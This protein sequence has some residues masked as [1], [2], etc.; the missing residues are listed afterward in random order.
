[1]TLTPTPCRPPD[2]LYAL[3]SN[4]P[5]AWSIV[6]A[7]STPGRRSV[8]CRSTGMPR[9]LS[10]TVMELSAW[11]TTS[12]RVQ[13]PASASSTALSTTSYT[14]WCRPRAPVEPMYMPGRR[15]TA[16]RPLRTW[17]WPALYSF[18][19]GFC[20]A[21]SPSLESGGKAT[22]FIT[23]ETA[24]GCPPDRVPTRSREPT[25][26]ASAVSHHETNPRESAAPPAGVDPPQDLALHQ[27]QLHEPGTGAHGDDEDAVGDA[28]RRRH[29][30][31]GRP[32][33]LRPGRD[34]A[35]LL[36]LPG[37]PR[38]LEVPGEDLAQRRRV[39]PL[40]AHTVILPA[41][42]C[43]RGRR[44]PRG[45]RSEAL[46]AVRRTWPRSSASRRSSKR[47]ARPGSSSA[48]TSSSRIMGSRPR[49]ARTVSASI[50]R[51]AI[52]TVLRWPPEP[53][54]RRSTELAASTNSRSSRCG[55][56][57]VL[58]RARSRET[59]RRSSA[60]NASATSSTVAA[61]AGWWRARP[62]R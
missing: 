16:S 19:F 29:G 53:N 6:I 44:P 42:M 54:S 57:C 56:A 32:H 5:P 26:W 25:C 45:S 30:R 21:I 40:L 48:N 27:P 61:A 46:G 3:L 33:E 23:P 37:E 55:P 59:P 7:T 11:I 13:W 51:S 38:A 28:E 22:P 49:P 17:I 10:L 50:M 18:P 24:S 4:L 9:P 36:H 41:S 31:D 12:M 14:R 39:A 60:R 43:Q 47:T 8:G 58:P 20:L 2:T 34:H 15:R 52:A 62:G 35:R 1:T